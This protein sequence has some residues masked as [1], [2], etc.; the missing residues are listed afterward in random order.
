MKIRHCSFFLLCN[1]IDDPSDA[2]MD[3]M[4]RALNVGNEVHV[5]GAWELMTRHHVFKKGTYIKGTTKS[6][7]DGHLGDVALCVICEVI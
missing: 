5:V 1:A 6:I 4:G 7:A 3:L 2:V